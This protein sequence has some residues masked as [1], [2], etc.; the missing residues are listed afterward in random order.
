MITAAAPA[1]LSGRPFPLP[2][3]S[4]A[5]RSSPPPAPSIL[6]TLT[7]TLHLHLRCR[8]VIE[9]C[10]AIAAKLAQRGICDV[11]Y[12]IATEHEHSC[13]VLLAREDKFLIDGVWHT[14]IDYEKFHSL[15]ARWQAEENKR[16]AN[17]GTSAEAKGDG[18]EI[19]DPQA[20]DAPFSFT[21]TD[22]MLPTPEWAVYKNALNTKGFDPVESRWKRTKTGKMVEIDYKSSESG[23]G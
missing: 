5:S 20:P 4:I 8:D 19:V 21:S 11:K 1:F 23:C 6:L 13:C 17:I 15:I 3:C 16:L 14:W 22:Y 10:E 18:A 7:L 9:F 12:S 2:P